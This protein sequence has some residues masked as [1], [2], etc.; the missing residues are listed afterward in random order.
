MNGLKQHGARG[1]I[2]LY[3]HGKK[4]L[5]TTKKISLTN[6]MNKFTFLSPFL[7]AGYP[8]SVSRPY[9]GYSSWQMGASIASSLNMVLATQSLLFAIGLGAGSIPMAAALNWIIKDGLG[10]VG[11]V[12]Y[13]SMVNNKFDA[14]PKRWRM[15]SALALDGAIALEIA[16]P[17]FPTHFLLLASIA[18]I[19]KNVAWLSAS[20]TRANMHQSFSKVGNLADVTAKAGSQS[21]AASILGIFIIYKF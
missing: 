18:N 17:L 1:S 9:L 13:A 20:A 11:G 3:Q 6:P 14:D 10:Q 5:F 8:S 21:I 7:P 4:W 2:R 15:V 16:T 12:L 19:G